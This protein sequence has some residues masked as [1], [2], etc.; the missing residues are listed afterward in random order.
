MAGETPRRGGEA[1]QATAAERRS[2]EEAALGMAGRVMAG[3]EQ[4]VQ[5][6]IAARLRNGP[7]GRVW[8]TSWATKGSG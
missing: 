7:S 5:G 6:H 1:G 4:G 2:D 3:G 8:L